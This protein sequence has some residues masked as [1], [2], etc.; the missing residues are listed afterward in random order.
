[1]YRGFARDM[2]NS[3]SNANRASCDT[4]VAVSAARAS[5]LDI[6]FVRRQAPRR[7]MTKA[8]FC[9]RST[10][11]DASKRSLTKSKTRRASSS[12][13]SAPG[14]VPDRDE[15]S[16]KMMADMEAM[17]KKYNPFTVRRG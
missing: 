9:G 11:F 17:A 5:S 8:R 13:S 1:M 10:F 12:L 14:E 7:L 3:S 4:P 6:A 15:M 16:K 2:T